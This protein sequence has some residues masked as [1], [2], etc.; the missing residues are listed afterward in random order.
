MIECRTQPELDA[1]L[2]KT[3]NGAK[4]LVVCLGDGYFTVTGSATVEAWDSA[5]V[6]AGGSA[7]VRAG[8]SATVRAWD[9][10]TVRAGGSATVE[11]W[12]SATV[13]AGDSATVEAWD[14]A[15][16]RAGGSAT[17]RAWDSATVRAGGSAT[18]GA[19]GSATV[20]AWDASQVQAFHHSR[21]TASDHVAVTRRSKDAKVTGGV[22][23]EIP[24]INTPEAWCDFHGAEVE[25]GVA[26][27]YKAVGDDYVSSHAF[28]YVPGTTPEAPDWDGGKEECGGGLHACAHPWE[29]RQFNSFATRYIAC[30]VRLEDI[31]VHENAAMPNKVKF[32]TCCEPC[33]E[34]D[35]DGE[36]VS[37]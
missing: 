23:I 7:T 36:K 28:A 9:S 13:E 8:G 30:P 5:T 17:V 33:W 19:G 2:A 32:R 31:A 11:A 24:P 6:R 20:R 27:L 21:I 26:V 29:A 14:S 3:E 12:G 34:V 18:V 15:T 16:V 35:V 22:V 4:E 25:D 10:T 37:K 1:A